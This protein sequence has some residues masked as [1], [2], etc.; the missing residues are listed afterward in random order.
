MVQVQRNRFHFNWL[1]HSGRDYPTYERV[2]PEFDKALGKFMAFLEAE[3]LGEIRPNQWEVTYVNHIPQGALWHTPSDWPKVL[4]FLS[5]PDVEAAGILPESL[6]G[7]WHYEI[8]EQR[9]RLHV[10][11]KHARETGGEGRMLLRFT[12]TARGPVAGE[13]GKGLELGEGLDLGRATIVKTFRALT[14]SE[15]RDHWE[16]IQDD[17]S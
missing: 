12:L 16:E 1:G 15:A 8:A 2:R 3:S 9:G 4:T 13:N 11:L 10:E 17:T 7:Q 14:S 6:I 5:S